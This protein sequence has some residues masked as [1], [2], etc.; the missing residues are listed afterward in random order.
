MNRLSGPDPTIAF[1]SYRPT[2]ERTLIVTRVDQ[3][4]LDRDSQERIPTSLAS[5]VFL[6][7]Q[8]LNHN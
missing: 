2:E 1:E 6:N 3:Y 4:V 5:C 8:S 7:A